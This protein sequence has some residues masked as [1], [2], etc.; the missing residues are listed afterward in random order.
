MLARISSKKLTEWQAFM[1]HREQQREEE[2]ERRERESR[3]T[4]IASKGRGARR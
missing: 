4:G 2:T 3:A 1:I